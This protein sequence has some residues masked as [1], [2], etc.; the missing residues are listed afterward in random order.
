MVKCYVERDGTIIREDGNNIKKWYVGESSRFSHCCNC[1]R[2]LA[3][4]YRC[5]KTSQSSDGFATCNEGCAIDLI[6]RGHC[7]TTHEPFP[8]HPWKYTDVWTEDQYP[9]LKRVRDLIRLNNP[10]VSFD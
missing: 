3:S 8:F 9:E 10:D 2:R 7:A 5:V 4:P 1:G 6:Q